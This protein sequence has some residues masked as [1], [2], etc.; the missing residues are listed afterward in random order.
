[1]SNSYSLPVVKLRAIE[2]EDLDTM[3]SIE[4]DRSIWNVSVTNVPY[5]KQTILNYIS[6]SVSDIYVDRQ[7][8]MMVENIYGEIVGIVDIVNFE[9]SHLRAE[10]GIIISPEFSGRGYGRA[11]LNAVADYAIRIL[12]LHQ[13]YA[14]VSVN[15]ERSLKMFKCCGYK[16]TSCLKEWL[17]DGKNYVDALMLQVFL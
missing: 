1:M 16:E 14:I 10:I 8:R 12:H 6:N 17:Y 5:S 11:V 9:P 3:Y 4:N 15:N 13:L 2:P 7:V